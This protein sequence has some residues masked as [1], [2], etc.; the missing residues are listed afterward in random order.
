VQ[1]QP[2]EL[3]T[4]YAYGDAVTDADLANVGEEIED[5]GTIDR[6]AND[7]GGGEDEESDPL[8]GVDELDEDEEGDIGEPDEDDPDADD[9]SES[10]PAK[11][12]RKE[13]EQPVPGV[14]PTPDPRI[15]RFE[16]W[17]AI[18]EE[19]EAAGFQSAAHAQ[20]AA[21]AQAQAA[22]AQA[23]RTRS[24]AS[25]NQMK[26]ELDEQVELGE[27]SPAERD[28]KIR[29]ETVTREAEARQAELAARQEQLDAQV[30]DMTI[31]N[32]ERTSLPELAHVPEAKELLRGYDGA[33]IEAVS[34]II[35]KIADTRAKLAIG[36]YA[37]GKTKERATVPP[38]AGAKEPSG[39]TKRVNFNDMSWSD[40]IK[41]ENKQPSRTR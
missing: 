5:F 10:P 8:D 32:I 21:Q 23:A 28:A 41:Y 27:I 37:A 22:E 24:V 4:L 17:K 39:L 29:L 30:R 2:Q 19:G 13:D 3:E 11:K 38:E 15:E 40:T 14:E 18:I 1:V 16:R 36:K 12:N 31:N 7:D 9:L 25:F 34:A 6:T 20:Q 26:A 33:D 35:N